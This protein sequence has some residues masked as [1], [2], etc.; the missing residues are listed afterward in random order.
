M[1]GTFSI[2]KK[3][4][5]GLFQRKN[6]VNFFTIINIFSKLEYKINLNFRDTFET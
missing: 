4:L 1:T 6:L 3:I 2:N 5:F